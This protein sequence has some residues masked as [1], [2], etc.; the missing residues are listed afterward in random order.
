MGPPEC[1]IMHELFTDDLL[2]YFHPN[3]SDWLR[4]R[5]VLRV[6]PWPV[7]HLTLPLHLV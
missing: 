7:H 3:P 6:V 4:V 2:N 5:R 1:G